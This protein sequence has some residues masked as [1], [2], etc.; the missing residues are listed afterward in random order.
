MEVAKQQ[1][2]QVEKS[3]KKLEEQI[4]SEFKFE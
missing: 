2:K 4:N 1:H 3:N